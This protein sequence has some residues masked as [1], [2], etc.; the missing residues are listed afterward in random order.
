MRER[1]IMYRQTFGDISPS[2][3]KLGKNL[4]LTDMNIQIYAYDWENGYNNES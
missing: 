4:S 3:V 1:E 2:G